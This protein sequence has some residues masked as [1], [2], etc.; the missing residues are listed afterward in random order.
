MF[1]EALQK[2]EFT[3]TC[4]FVPGRGKEGPGV[5]AAIGFA[6]AMAGSATQIH[7]VSL[8]DNPGGNTAMTPDALAP[9]I[10]KT[11][12]TALAHFSCRD[13][14]RNA[15]ESRAM[16]LARSGVNTLLIVT[17]DYPASGFEGN[18]AGVF[19]L[20]AVQAVK[21]LKA[22]NAGLEI[23][24]MKKGTTARLP[25][26]DFFVAAAVSPFKFKEE[27]LLPQ[28][29]KLEKKIAAGADFVI[30]QLGYDMRKFLEVK[31][32]MASRGLKVP[33][34][35]NVYVLS[36]GAAKTMHAGLVPG[37]VVTDELLSVLEEESKDPDKGKKKRLERAAKMMAMFKGMGFNGVH[38]GGFALKTEDFLYIINRAAELEPQ[39]EAFIPEVA[40]GRKDE[41]YAFPPPK[42]YRPGEVDEDPVKKLPASPGVLGYSLSMLIHRLAFEHG[43]L[44]CRLLT[45]YYKLI[46]ERSLLARL[47]HCNEHLLKMLTF[48][49]R[50]CGDCALPDMA[51]C[52]PQGKC[53]KQQRNGPCGGSTRGMCEVYPDEK[54]CVW[55]LVYPR[56]KGAGKVEEMRTQ[57]VPPRKMELSFTSGWANYFLSR[58]HAAP[59]T[60]AEAPESVH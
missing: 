32:Y 12:L 39:W 20:D 41:Y 9:E 57:Y 4:E 40:F 37:C 25:P 58:D 59:A 45:G 17:G 46:G 44:G 10:Q 53:A 8:T 27:E 18:A 43:S 31:R 56:L 51:Y 6:K 23:P 38:I 16:A 50:D 47:S 60:K 21:Y 34:I 29:F 14:N 1:R 42:T 11:G 7:A 26:T 35:G 24:G 19:D 52:C 54:P 15:F 5:E 36:Y 30:P 33:L 55:T 48:A 22:M 28:F 2:G 3:I 13:L 49:C